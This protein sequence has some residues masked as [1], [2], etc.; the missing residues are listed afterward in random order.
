MFPA[1]LPCIKRIF[2]QKFTKS[3]T[4]ANFASMICKSKKRHKIC[5]M[6]VI[7]SNRASIALP[8]LFTSV[9]SQWM[10]VRSAMRSSSWPA[11]A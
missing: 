9:S 11:M 8:A 4:C 1:I 5:H 3:V 7:R 6:A 2:V 10:Y